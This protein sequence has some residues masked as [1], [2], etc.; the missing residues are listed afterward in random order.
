M[1]GHFRVQSIRPIKSVLIVLVLLVL[2]T[3]TAA[4]AAPVIG[5]FIAHDTGGQAV[6]E[7]MV[8]RPAAVYYNNVTYVAYQGPGLD[9]YVIAFNHVERTWIG[10]IKVGENPLD[11]ARDMHGAPSITVDGA[12]YL[13]V[14]YGAHASYVRHA[15][16]PGPGNIVPSVPGALWSTK[17]SLSSTRDEYGTVTSGKFTYP[18]PYYRSGAHLLVVRNEQ[19]DNSTFVDFPYKH[20]WSVR[21]LVDG[22]TSWEPTPTP[23]VRDSADLVYDPKTS[24]RWYVNTTLDPATGDIHAALVA[25]HD[26]SPDPYARDGVYYMR[27]TPDGRRLTA[28]GVE[29]TST[30]QPGWESPDK[31][32]DAAF[33][34][35]WEGDLK[36]AGAQVVTPSV[37]PE[38]LRQN[39]VVVRIDPSGDPGILYLSGSSDTYQWRF[40]RWNNA[41]KAWVSSPAICGTDQ[42]FD[43][44]TFEFRSETHISAYVTTEGGTTPLTQT[45][46]RGGSI[47]RYDSTNGGTSWTEN[48]TLKAA[49][50]LYGER[51]NDPQL[52][53]GNP[54]AEAR[55]VFCQWDNAGVNFVNKLFLSSDT[56]SLM[57]KEVT[58]DFT[59]LSGL[60]RIATSIAISKESFPLGSNWAVLAASDNFPDALAGVPLA[61]AFGGPILLVPK[62]GLT[63]ELVIELQRLRI[64]GYNKADSG[65]IILGGTAA[66]PDSI[67][68]QVAS[69]LAA[70][71]SYTATQFRA[72]VS[73]EAGTNRFGTA[74]EIA[75]RLKERRGATPSKAVVVSGETFADAL[76]VSPV[77]AVNGW[78]ILLTESS[79]VTSTTVNYVKSLGVA[80]TYVIGGSAVVPLAAETRLPG[81]VRIAGANRYVTS[82]NVAG[83][84]AANGLRRERL[85]IASGETF[86]D[87]LA[88]GVL[89]A[90]TRGPL[91]ITSPRLEATGG[92]ESRLRILLAT[93]SSKALEWYILGGEKAVGTPVAAEISSYLPVTE[94]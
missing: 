84:G 73:R 72:K 47:K 52:V 93:S 50:P 17:P 20:G 11:A 88:G 66:L 61:H 40:E 87:A 14:F 36:A 42:F 1:S 54:P 16:S 8:V 4:S 70:T 27:I 29:I 39:Q 37:T 81:V 2:A 26:V 10:P 35:P 31:Q 45:T 19:K 44:A 9:P 38:D 53:M 74:I 59:R 21:R 80:T 67:R 34:G 94:P 56:G 89:A 60:D 43:S 62:T 82:Y 48:A 79:A 49:D 33:Y 69:A 83:F 24:A 55:V 25:L 65:V 58:S 6:L 86:P 57:Q 23:I 78:P 63:P 41:T 22:A 75:D 12:G 51:Y 90:R 64:S 92:L 30:I 15:I 18:Q 7:D 68:D 71:S 46:N 76:T 91:L 32:Y 77:A 85:T 13:H 5:D 3:A 28:A